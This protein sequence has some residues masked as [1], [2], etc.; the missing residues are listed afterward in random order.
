MTIEEA[1][2]AGLQQGLETGRSEGFQDAWDTALELTLSLL[3]PELIPGT[4]AP[5]PVPTRVVPDLWRAAPRVYPRAKTAVQIMKG[6][7]W[8]WR[9]SERKAT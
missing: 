4:S 7:E 8:S 1:Y 3:G 2:A 5:I 6:A 9:Q